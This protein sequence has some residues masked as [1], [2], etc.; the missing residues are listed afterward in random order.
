MTILFTAQNGRA[1]WRNFALCAAMI[2]A[3]AFVH[4]VWYLWLLPVAAFFFAGQFRW[5][6]LLA[7]AWLAGTVFA[8]L[9]TGHPA[10]YLSE[11]VTMAFH[12][13]GQHATNRT[14]VTELQPFGGDILAVIIVG[15]LVALRLA[16]KSA[17]PSFAKNPAF[18]LVCGCWILGF[19]VGRFWEDWGWPALMVLIATEIQ[20]LLLAKFAADSLRRLLLAM[21]LAVATFFAVTNDLHSRWTGS[22]T[23]QFLSTAEHPE[24]EGWMPEKGGILYSAD[25][26]VFYQTFFKNPKADWKY[27]LGFDPTFMTKEDFDVY[28]KVEW[29]SGAAK[30][31]APWVQKMKPADRLVIRGYG[32]AK[33]N[34]E[35]LEWNYGVSGIWIGRLPRASAK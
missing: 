19:R 30:A 34:S 24:L 5:T 12:S 23:W 21:I 7:G 28:H 29:N 22:L 15:A 9:L 13:V 16:T 17:S 8:A 35:Q 20:S 32:D 11:A 33:P 14:E 25:M 1:N 2:A 3:S 31:Y 10:D 18:W 6:L 4:G 26:T 27:I